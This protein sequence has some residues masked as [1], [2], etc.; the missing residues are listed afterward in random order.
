MTQYRCKQFFGIIDLGRQYT[1]SFC[2]KNGKGLDANPE[3]YLTEILYYFNYI[4][5]I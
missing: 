1:C 3:I 4:F 2:S 5:M